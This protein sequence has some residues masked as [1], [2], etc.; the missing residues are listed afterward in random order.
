MTPA[1]RALR[2]VAAILALC[3]VGLLANRWHASRAFDS[4]RARSAALGLRIDLAAL[5]HERSPEA[6]AALLA[7]HDTCNTIGERGIA[8]YEAEGMPVEHSEERLDALTREEAHREAEAVEAAA[9]R[10]LAA[11]ASEE[12]GEI[13]RREL[14]TAADGIPEARVQPSSVRQSLVDCLSGAARVAIADGAHAQGWRW[15]ELA[16]EVCA[17]QR[18]TDM[19]GVSFMQPMLRAL[20]V[21]YNEAVVA[22]PD[23]PARERVRVL[24]RDVDIIHEARAALRNDASVFLSTVDEL[25]AL[26]NTHGLRSRVFAVD[27]RDE[28]MLHRTWAEIVEASEL[29]STADQLAALAAVDARTHALPRTY[30]LTLLT[31]P[32][33]LSFWEHA[34]TIE[35]DRTALLAE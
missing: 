17:T 30:A 4:A 19:L 33:A 11:G 16:A 10:F 1:L 24:L 6:R 14:S 28:A 26:G 2:L 20:R 34:Q 32:R 35:A 29:A 3:A 13:L 22:A 8:R 27:L 25:T 23:D 18:G 7:A 15:I 21:A 31:V 9:M 12:P 5:P